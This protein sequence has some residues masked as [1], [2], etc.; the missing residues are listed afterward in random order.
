MLTVNAAACFTTVNDSATRQG[1]CFRNPFPQNFKAK[2]SITLYAHTANSV[3]VYV[4]DNNTLANATAGDC[5]GFPLA[6]G[7]SITIE[8][9]DLSKIF[10]DCVP[11]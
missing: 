3:S 10:L 5:V 4:G 11:L 1:N 7:A 9:T 2:R 8:I 6:P